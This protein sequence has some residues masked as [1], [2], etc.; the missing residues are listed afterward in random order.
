MKISKN[1]P[2]TPT[3]PTREAAGSGKASKAPVTAPADAVAIA[4]IPEAELTPKVRAALTALMGEVASLRAE[5]AETRQRMSDLETLADSDPMLDVLNRR[6]FVRE[7]NR[8]LAMVERYGTPSS[9]VFLDLDNLKTIN[10]HHGHAAG[11]AALTHASEII[12]ANIRQTDIFGRLGGDEF[13]IILVQSEKAEALIKAQSLAD[14]IAR[15]E[16]STKAGP[17]KV[18][19]SAGVVEIVKGL[20]AEEALQS[21][22]AAMYEE[23]RKS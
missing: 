20:S 1:A 18:T 22:D 15:D 13:A 5:L 19:M 12:S 3:N 2:T 11:D 16:I 4:G 23:K 6:A 8:A 21:A 14:L 10:D 9:L 7:F 17:I